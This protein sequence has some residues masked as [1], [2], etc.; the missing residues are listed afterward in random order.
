MG[1]DESVTLQNVLITF[2]DMHAHAC[3][4]RVSLRPIWEVRCYQ[5]PL[6]LFCPEG[7]LD[8]RAA[9]IVFQADVTSPR[10]Q[11]LEFIPNW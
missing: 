5:V 10:L 8:V 1:E 4:C 7:L 3:G 2:P 6:L 9:A 11:A